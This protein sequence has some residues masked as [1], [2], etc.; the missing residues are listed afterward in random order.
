MNGMANC[1]IC[2]CGSGMKLRAR[3]NSLVSTRDSRAIRKNFSAT[4]RSASAMVLKRSRVRSTCPNARLSRLR[5]ETI[6]HRKCPASDIQFLRPSRVLAP[7]ERVDIPPLN[8]PTPRSRRTA[9]L[10]PVPHRNPMRDC[11]TKCISPELPHTALISRAGVPH[12]VLFL[13]RFRSRVQIISDKCSALSA[14]RSV[15]GEK[16]PL[17]Q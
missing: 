4:L 3:E 8:R 7:P 6:S 15:I 13:G 16:S 5:H 9:A 10:P 1:S 11:E 17:H 14:T 2:F 12:E